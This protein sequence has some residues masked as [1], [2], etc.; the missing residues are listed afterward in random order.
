MIG[1]EQL[2]MFPFAGQMHLCDFGASIAECPDA[3]NCQG[4]GGTSYTPSRLYDYAIWGTRVFV[5]DSLKMVFPNREDEI[6]STADP[7]EYGMEY[8]W[9]R[10]A[11]I[12]IFMMAVVD[13]L[14]ATMSLA[15]LLV[16]VPSEA[17]SWITYDVPD[18]ADKERVKAL[19]GYT[20]LDFVKFHVAGMPMG[21]KVL[22][23]F[24]VL[25][26]KCAMW[27]A[28]VC[29]G[30]HYLMESA[31]IM[32]VVVNAMALTFVL[33]VDEMIFLRLSTM[34]TKHI[35]SS[36]EDMPLF[37]TNTEETETEHEVLERFHIDEVG[38]GRLRRINLLLPKRL[39]TIVALQFF[40]MWLYYQRNCV[41]LEDGSWV[42]KDMHLPKDLAYRPLSLM[43]GVDPPRE[44]KPFW[45]FK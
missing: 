18:W 43:F 6:D 11:C 7:G 21:W 9:C 37:E 1:E 3:A 42:S 32:A 31:G 41:R 2:V 33:D 8:Y 12:F 34:I 25:V 26:P 15:N 10:T 28:L 36:L 39:L 20:E 5:R 19:H 44:E 17:E 22:N 4:P 23:F 13:D 30:V 40:F 38:R 45:T 29:S 16:A 14:W 24:I 35:M 27:V